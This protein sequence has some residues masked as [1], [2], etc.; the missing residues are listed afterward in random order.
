MPFGVA[1]RV[2]RG[3]L[4]AGPGRVCRDRADG[5]GR[6]APMAPGDATH[7][8]SHDTVAQGPWAPAFIAARSGPPYSESVSVSGTADG[9]SRGRIPRPGPRGDVQHPS[10]PRPRWACEPPAHRGRRAGRSTPTWSGSR[11]STR[12]RPSSSPATSRCSSSPEP[13]SIALTAPTATPSSRGS[14]SRGWPP[15]T[16]PCGRARRAAAFGSTSGFREQTLHVFNVHLGLRGRERAEQVKWLVE[17][18]ILWD[19]RTGP[20]IVIGDLNEWFPGRVGRA[21]RREFTSLRRRLTHPALLPLW[22]L[23]RIYWDHAVRGE[24]LRVHRTRAGARRLR[25]PAARSQPPDSA[26]PRRAESASRLS[27]RR[28][29]LSPRRTRRRP[30]WTV[31]E[32]RKSPTPA[33]APDAASLAPRL[34]DPPHEETHDMKTL[35]RRSSDGKQDRRARPRLLDRSRSSSRPAPATAPPWPR[36]S[37]SATRST[38]RR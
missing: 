33:S 27:P 14:R 32:R 20:R 6:L 11:R 9:A 15:S 24:S 23:D 21:L 28:A 3:L 37:G 38:A 35:K 31:A 36:R 10:G 34:L 1:R 4:S 19:D 18:H 13:P 2:P 30:G 29:I 16:S 5:P 25:P 7:C 12:R 17:R 8:R 22:A 26:R